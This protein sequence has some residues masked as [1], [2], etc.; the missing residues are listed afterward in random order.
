MLMNNVQFQHGLAMLEF[1][2]AHGTQQQ[3]EE[4]V[5]AWRWPQAGVF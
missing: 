1:F 4:I 2:Y 3:C 5:R